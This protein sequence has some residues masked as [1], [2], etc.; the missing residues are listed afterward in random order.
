MNFRAKNSILEFA[1]SVMTIFGIKIW[2]N[3]DHFTI[4]LIH[5][6]LMLIHFT[7][8]LIHF[9]LIVIRFT[10]VSIHFP[11]I[12]IHCILIS[13]HFTIIL[14][15]FTLLCYPFF[16]CQ[17]FHIFSEK[18]SGLHCHSTVDLLRSSSTLHFKSKF[19]GKCLFIR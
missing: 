19:L 13:I 2:W 7:L 3:Q 15:H 18:I 6:T 16:N 4:L 5:F 10:L 14:I 1:K 17:F 9:T 11:L 12:V 8:I